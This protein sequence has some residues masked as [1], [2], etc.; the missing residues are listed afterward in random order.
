MPIDRGM[1]NKVVIHVYNEILLIHRKGHIMSFVTIW[2]DLEIVTL[3]DASDRERQMSYDTAYV[4]NL[5]NGTDELI[6]KTEVE[7]QC[8]KH[9]VVIRVE[10]GLGLTFT[11][12]YM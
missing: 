5:K 2:M 6:C 7:S 9:T 3:S 8:R 12:Y 11:L 4:W 10:R 1:D